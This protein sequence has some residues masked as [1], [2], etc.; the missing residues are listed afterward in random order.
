MAQFGAGI[1]FS[2]SNAEAGRL[3]E[4]L[5]TRINGAIPDIAALTERF[6]DAPFVS[7]GAAG[8]LA[9]SLTTT[10]EQRAFLALHKG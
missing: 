2:R 4:G 8:P 1:G 6:M 9:G 5:L 3:G 10:E 7:G